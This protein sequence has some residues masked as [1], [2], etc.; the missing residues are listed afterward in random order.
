MSAKGQK[1][2]LA[3]ISAQ[4]LAELLKDGLAR[5]QIEMSAS[6]VLE[7]RDVV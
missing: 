1:Q 6:G 4:G 7:K 3:D 5:H 2:T